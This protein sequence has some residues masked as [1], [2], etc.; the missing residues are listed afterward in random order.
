LAGVLLLVL[1]TGCMGTTGRIAQLPENAVILAPNL[2]LELPSPGEMGRSLE[3]V[4]MVT[5]H[6]NG[7]TI[8]FEAHLSVTPERV[9]L[10]GIDATGQRLMTVTWRDTQIEVVTSPYLPKEVRPGAMLADLVALYWPEDVVRHALASSGASLSVDAVSRVVS[11]HGKTVLEAKY[12]GGTAAP[13]SGGL[14][15][16]NLSWGYDIDVETLQVT[17]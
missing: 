15:Y 17:P 7:Q 2:R 6:R 16:R 12:P 8:A 13:W 3:A 1:L 10:V 14:H 9:L 5:A 4:Q 11:L